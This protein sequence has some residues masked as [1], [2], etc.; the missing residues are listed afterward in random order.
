MKTLII[1][2][3]LFLLVIAFW[4]AKNWATNNRNEKRRLKNLQ[5]TL[6]HTDKKL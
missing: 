4:A 1:I 6:T 5:K 3:I 2:V